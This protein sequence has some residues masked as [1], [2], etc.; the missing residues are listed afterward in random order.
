MLWLRCRSFHS[1]LNSPAHSFQISTTMPPSLLPSLCELALPALWI[2]I[3]LALSPSWFQPHFLA[4]SLP[5]STEK[6]HATQP[7]LTSYILI[8][9]SLH[10][11]S[12]I[13]SELLN[14]HSVI[15]QSSHCPHPEFPQRPTNEPN[16]RR[17]SPCAAK[18]LS[19]LP[20]AAQIRDRPATRPV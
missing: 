13:T 18:S 14:Y 8:T 2:T 20:A 9:T 12:S 10:C 19:T 5:V 1:V 4:P 17:A 7:Q 15:F 16:K 6:P 11:Q 3:P